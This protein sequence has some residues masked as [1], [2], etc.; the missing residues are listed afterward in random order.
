[1]DTFTLHRGSAPLLISLPHDG[2]EIPEAIAATMTP[3]ARRVPDTDWHV[4]RLYAFARELGASILT[5]RHSRYVVDL[6]RPPDDVSLYPGQN[7]TGLCPAVQF[8]GE[9]VYLPGMAPDPGAVSARVEQYWRP[10]HT[11]LAG[12]LARLREQ[13]GRAV[14]WDGHSIRSV[15]PFLFEGRLP[16]FNLG[17]AG[18]ASCSDNLQQRLVGVL[19]G[20]ADHSFVVNGRFRG[21]YITRHYGRPDQGVDAV[22]LELAQSTYMDE[23]EITYDSTRAVPTQRLIQ[24]LL[25]AVIA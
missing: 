15:V 14:L 6:N 11:A 18:G 4:S 9:P 23:D 8:S 22:Q 24:R 1:M 2:T 10:Y 3:S 7:T 25:E 17:T 16:D 13:H 21:G 5:P 12:E 20:Q 19:E